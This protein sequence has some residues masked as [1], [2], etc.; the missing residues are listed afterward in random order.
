MR[1]IVGIE[2]SQEH[3]G[4]SCSGSSC[5]ILTSELL[6]PLGTV[7]GTDVDDLGLI[8]VQD[9][10]W[11]SLVGDI[12]VPSEINGRKLLGEC[13]G[14]WEGPPCPYN[15]CPDG[16]CY[17]CSSNP[18]GC[19]NGCGPAKWPSAATKYI[20]ELTPFGNGCCNHDYCWSAKLDDKAGC[21][22]AFWVDN[23]AGCLSTFGPLARVFS[24][25]FAACNIVGTAFYLAVARGGDEA[26][27]EAV[28]EQE[29]W[30]KTCQATP[31]PSTPPEP[32]SLPVGWF[33]ARNSRRISLSAFVSAILVFVCPVLPFRTTGGIPHKALPV[34]L[35][36]TSGE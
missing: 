18:T 29:D 19:D 11:E 34:I 31:A 28:K 7:S 14:A 33:V 30:E 9:V 2:A 15:D 24:K 10:A 25:A 32:V 6:T 35:V 3:S 20:A 5:W 26:H 16:K 8:D 21:D 27:A 17:E 13:R 1:K 4:I 22:L 23:L 12:C 36:G